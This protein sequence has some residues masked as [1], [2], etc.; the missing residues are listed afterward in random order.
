MI[1]ASVLTSFRVL[2][3]TGG[4][5]YGSA[6]LILGTYMYI[7]GHV[8]RITVVVVVVVNT[9]TAVFPQE[10]QICKIGR[11]SFK[12]QVVYQLVRLLLPL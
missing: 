10:F 1:G 6:A 5:R 12:V 3:V 9:I 4:S 8:R 7:A 11:T 2:L